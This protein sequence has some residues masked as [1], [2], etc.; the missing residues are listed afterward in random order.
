M[1]LRAVELVVKKV[2]VHSL[3]TDRSERVHAG[4]AQKELDVGERPSA[5]TDK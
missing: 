3:F 1:P 2:A 5:G 4:C